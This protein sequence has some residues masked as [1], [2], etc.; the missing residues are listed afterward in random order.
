M[1]ETAI[2]HIDDVWLDLP[3]TL[4]AEAPTFQ[5]TLGE[6]L[7]H[8]I[9]N[10]DEPRQYLLRPLLAQIQRDAQLAGV[11]VVEGAAHVHA[12]PL[13]HERWGAAQDVPTAFVRRVFD[14][15]DL[16][17]ERRQPLGGA[18]AGQLPGEVADAERFEGACHARCRRRAPFAGLKPRLRRV[19]AE[20]RGAACAARSAS[21]PPCE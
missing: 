13:I 14:A 7:A 20:T 16:G 8:H 2:G 6:V 9:G 4:V 15:D 5:H 1:A 11:V 17:A 18:G 12:A 10:A 21:H 3:Q 19:A